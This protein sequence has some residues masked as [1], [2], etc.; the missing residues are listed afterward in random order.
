MKISILSKILTSI[1]LILFFTL[2]SSN[3]VSAKNKPPPIP[4]PYQ[5]NPAPDV[6]TNERFFEINQNQYQGSLYLTPEGEMNAA[7]FTTMTANYLTGFIGLAGFGE[8]PKVSLNAGRPP[9][10]GAIGIISQLSD[11]LIT[12]P[13]V[14]TTEY[15]ADLGKSIGIKP[16][17]AQEGQT[18]Q[19]RLSPVLPIWKAFR[20]LAYLIFVIIFVIVGFMIMF[21]AKINPQTV[22][23]I[24]SAIPNLIITLIVITFSYAIVSLMID[25]I[26]VSI[27]LIIGFLSSSGV[28]GTGAGKEVIK[29]SIFGGSVLD[30]GTTNVFYG[31]ETAGE[32]VVYRAAQA[33][34]QTVN[35]LLW[36]GGAG[37][38]KSALTQWITGNIV[39]AIFA[40]AVLFS[41]FK[42]F[43]QLLLSYIGIILAVIFAPLQL[44]TN[45]FPGSNSLVNWLKGLLANIL[46]FPAT[47]LLFLLAAALTGSSSWGVG[48]G[49]GYA[50]QSEG[51]GFPLL[52]VGNPEALQG[53]IGLGMIMMAPKVVS[54][55]KEAL[56]VEKG[57]GMG[58]AIA[59]IVGAVNMPLQG[60]QVATSYGQ[61]KSYFGKSPEG[62]AI[63]TVDNS[64][65]PTE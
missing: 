13:P 47:V 26:W 1:F 65:P 42:L 44:L 56:K 40:I 32:G 60:V 48:E 17:Y 2:I 39:Y 11:G 38:V 51:G 12:K 37:I 63:Q 5:N 61:L 10:T 59:P 21:R 31:S 50:G 19:Q 18:G 45:A 46:V 22:I 28:I 62:G 27:Y 35:E 9:R 55:I 7:K 4:D 43:F 54:M 24:E 64:N 30:I 25:F 33:V 49:V 41:L 20:N 14:S 3:F 36:G 53:L 52:V 58:A 16:V 34:G 29:T 23:S 57:A 15:L 8:T 6:V